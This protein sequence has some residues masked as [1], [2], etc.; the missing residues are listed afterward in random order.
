MSRNKKVALAAVAILGTPI[1]ALVVA[2]L[3]FAD[4]I[5]VRVRSEIERATQLRVSWEAHQLTFFRDFPHPTLSL[6]G[7]TALGTGRFDG[8]TLAAIGSF[9][10]S[11]DGTSVIP[12]LRGKGPLVVRSVTVEAPVLRLRVDEDGTTIWNP[13]P[14]GEGASG[15]EPGR[16]VALSLRRLEVI[17]GDVVFDN[18]Q[19][20]LFVSLEGL[21]HTLRGDFSRASLVADTR[22]HADA[23]TLR[24]AGAP[25]L[26]G[27]ALD[28]DAA[29]DID[30]TEG[31]ARLTDNELRLNDLVVRLAGEVGREGDDLRMDLTFAAPST[32][33]G[34]LLSLVPAI[35]SQDFASLESSGTFSFDGT[36]EGIYGSGSIPAFALAVAVRD[37]AFRYPDLPLPARAIRA[38]LSATNPG[39]DLDSTVVSLSDFHIE[40][41][42]QPLDASLTMRTPVSDP[43]ADVR[44]NGTVDLA[45]VARTVKLE[46]A[47]GLGGVIEADAR[48]RAR[49]SDVES[50]RYDRVDA[51]GTIAARD[52]TLRGESLRQPVDI[53]R[54]MIRLTPQAAEVSAFEARLGSSDVQATGRLDNLLAFALGEPTLTGTAR[55]TSSRMVLDE[56]RSGRELTAIPVP[57]MLDFTL[58]GTVEELV[59]NGLEMTGARGRAIV[60]DER[61]TLESVSLAALGG[62][63]G[64]DGFYETLGTAP[65]TFSLDLDFDSLDVAAS[66]AAFL[67]VRTLAPVAQYARGTF[68]SAL[69]LSGTLGQDLSPVL[70]LLDGDGSLRTSRIAIENF[71]MLDRLAETLQLQRLSHPTVDALRSTIRIQDGRL[72]VD[73]FEVGVAGLP[74]TVSGSNGIDQSVDYSIGLQVPRAGFADAALTSLASRAGPLGASLAAADPVR[75]GIRVTGSV[76]QPTLN[77]SLS[78]TTGSVRDATTR[79]AEAAVGQRIDEAQA[80]L[81]AERDEAQQRARARADSIVAE[82][83]RQAEVI[84][85][86]AGR[87]A[88]DVRAEGERAAAEVLARATN[89]LARTA[90]QPVADRIRREADE[91]ATAI[92][93]EADERATALVA[94]AQARADALVRGDPG[95]T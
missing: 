39:G 2:P 17:D 44:V 58:D 30:V 8:D 14:A 82:A 46:R 23:V 25:Y 89:P 34:Q 80:R 72:F 63:I 27:V 91:R 28:F 52:V 85:A 33:F 29:F 38:D 84:R 54:A 66:S 90:A 64:M 76:T 92:E 67:T 86:E 15:G 35:Y 88:A 16:S 47:E 71:P 61:L 65:P 3:L 94:E 57:A 22:T 10:L 7:L 1:L 19:S 75:V 45:A 79:A 56:W 55:F 87:V 11:L 83:G 37:G 4:R 42:G 60:R 43:D 21:A 6:T 13:E 73:P 48:A 5:E 49:R 69:S 78:E 9:R 70:E 50:A 95:P 41:D 24:F 59:F 68:S 40:I 77:V 18:E 51:Q 32:D 26:G 81:D 12:A 93:R 36:V 31:R 62:R 74:M 20:G 53:Q